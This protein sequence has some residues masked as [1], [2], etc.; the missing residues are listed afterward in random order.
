MRHNAAPQTLLARLAV[1]HNLHDTRHVPRGS[2]AGSGSNREL[3]M[4]RFNGWQAAC[5]VAI[6]CMSV[7][8]SAGAE[9]A[10]ER[11]IRAR[12][13]AYYLMGQQMGRINAA[14]RG[15]AALDRTSLQMSVE[16]VEMIGRLVV[17]YY[18]AGSDQGSTKARPEIWNEAP[19]FRQMVQGMQNE[20]AKLKAAVRAGDL[21]AIK[22]AFGATS[23]SCKACHDAYRTR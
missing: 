8:Q 21:D 20:T 17:D 16:A 14:L 18:P 4:K 13:S 11:A 6:T 1:A 5:A 3:Y 12:Q 7:P 23:K 15:D 22:D 19:R 9:S 10:Q 2:G